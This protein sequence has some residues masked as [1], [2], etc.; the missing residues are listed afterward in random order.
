MTA[1]LT[2][3]SSL[4]AVNPL[5]LLK[6][7]TKLNNLNTV[8]S[9]NGSLRGH[10][11]GSGSGGGPSGGGRHSCREPRLLPMDYEPRKCDVLCGR[12]SNNHVGNKYFRS[13]IS[14]HM[15][16]YINAPNR[17]QKSNLVSRIVQLVRHSGGNFIKLVE[18]GDGDDDACAMGLLNHGSPRDGHRQWYEIGDKLAKEKCGHAIRDMIAHHYN[19]S[20]TLTTTTKTD[21][22]AAKG[23]HE[24]EFS[25]SS[26]TSLSRSA[27][28]SDS[29]SSQATSPSFGDN[30]TMKDR[31]RSSSTVSGNMSNNVI[32]DVG[33]S[34]EDDDSSLES[35]D[36]DEGRKVLMVKFKRPK[37]ERRQRVFSKLLSEDSTFSPSSPSRSQRKLVE[38]VGPAQPTVTKSSIHIEE[39]RTATS[40]IGS[41]N[42]GVLLHQ[43]TLSTRMAISNA[44][45]G[46]TMMNT[47]ENNPL[48]LLHAAL[49]VQLQREQQQQQNYGS[50]GRGKFLM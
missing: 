32:I 40:S 4:A 12:M 24:E 14:M 9:K 48:E 43:Q 1:S 20:G 8:N 29:T 50:V 25:S 27:T 16:R 35:E 18:V 49:H 19:H 17:Q 13:L 41:C 34:N 33:S 30:P 5:P 39:P 6:I 37:K 7:P 31:N 10:G 15:E 38:F 23:S 26:S 46:L 28:P 2:T 42:S 44:L 45:R 36:E 22:L 11:G 47:T 21:A 3:P